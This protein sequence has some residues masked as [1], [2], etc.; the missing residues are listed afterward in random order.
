MKPANLARAVQDASYIKLSAEEVSELVKYI[1]IYKGNKCKEHYEV[2]N[3]ISTQ[4]RWGEFRKLR[5]M[6]DHGHIGRIR[7]IAPK[8][9]AIV[10]KVLSIDDAGGD[11][12]LDYERY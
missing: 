10:C 9:F 7:G 4:N 12:L 6:N 11:P 5:S 2:N 1:M 3:I 8:Y